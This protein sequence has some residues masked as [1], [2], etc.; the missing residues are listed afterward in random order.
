VKSVEFCVILQPE[1]VDAA[2]RLCLTSNSARRAVTVALSESDSV[3]SFIEPLDRGQVGVA[4]H[5]ND[6]TPNGRPIARANGPQCL[7]TIGLPRTCAVRTHHWFIG[8]V[9]E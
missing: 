6:A 2:R 7:E 8:P 1:R 9:Y 5:H 3:N 4:D